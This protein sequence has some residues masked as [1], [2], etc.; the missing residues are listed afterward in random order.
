VD[1]EKNAVDSEYKLGLENDRWRGAAVMRQVVNP[2]HPRAKFNVGNLDTLGEGV[3][4]ALL[5]FFEQNYSADQMALVAL[6][7]EPLD[8]LEAWITPMFGQVRNR[9]LGPSPIEVPLFRSADLPA[10]LRYKS[11]KEGHRVSYTFPV[12]AFRPHYRTKPGS[13]LANL[14][15]HEGEGSLYQR[16][17]REGWVES[18]AAGGESVDERTALLTVE[19]ALTDAGYARLDKITEALFDYVALLRA[20]PPQEF[21]YAEQ[22]RIAELGFEFQE[23][24]DAVRLVVSVAPGFM[25]YPPEEVLTGPILMTEFDAPLIETYTNALTPENLLMEVSGPDVPTDQRE[26]YYGVPYAIERALAP[27]A[28]LADGG[29]ALPARN[30][31]LPDDLTVLAD[32]PAPPRLAVDSP[33]LALWLDLDTEFDVPRSNLYLSLGIPDGIGSPEDLAMAT[34]YVRLVKDALSE[35]VYPAYLAGLGYDL[36]VDG[37]GFELS[38]SGYSEAQLSFLETLLDAFTGTEIDPARFAV[39]RDELLRDARNARDE[40]AYLQTFQ[41]I[42]YL[43]LS[44]RWPPQLLIPALEGATSDDLATWRARRAARFHVLGLRHGNVSDEGAEAL[45]AVLRERLTL[46]DFPR[47]APRVVE[48]AGARRYAVDTDQQDAAM[49]L[50][51]Q[52][53]DESVQSQAQ[54]RLAASVLRQAYFTDLRTEQQLGYVVEVAPIAVRR[55][56]GLAF[57]IQSPVASASRLER[58]TQDF[59]RQQLEVVAAM[60]ESTFE[61]YRQGVVSSLTERDKNLGERGGRLWSDLELGVTSFDLRAQIARQV[62]QIDRPALRGYLERTAARLAGDR[63]IIYCKGKF[64]EVPTRGELVRSLPE[65]KRGS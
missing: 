4:E 17:L 54:S 21:R 34:L 29:L 26:A 8:A 6:S 24:S 35:T 12:P 22:A 33:E 42:S 47:A 28:E 31:Y 36:D 45:A 1:R 44:N 41:A 46:A 11:I 16:L 50:Y 14:L 25:E 53:P 3:R 63:L 7:N 5:Q 18:L 59:M 56:G 38:V 55:R 20:S 39:L 32:D 65:F 27:R 61:S 19:I 23:P 15:G 60:P 58:V 2:A 37:F 40:P 48:V 64:D 43:L 10:V 51:L 9:E 52:D 30:P 62:Q 13:F 57:V 49:V